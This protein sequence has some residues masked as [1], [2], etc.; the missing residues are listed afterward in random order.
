VSFQ[1]QGLSYKEVLLEELATCRL[2]I[3]ILTPDDQ[4]KQPRRTGGTGLLGRD[5]VVF[6]AGLAA[7]RYGFERTM[8]LAETSVDLPT[9]WSGLIHIPF[10]IAEVK[11]L[12][13]ALEQPLAQ[14]RTAIRGQS[15]VI[16]EQ[17]RLLDRQR[18]DGRYWYLS[19]V[20]VGPGYQGVVQD[21]LDREADHFKQKHGVFCE[22]AGVLFGE[23]DDF[24]IF[25]APS[26][27]AATKFVT[28]LR[29]H[30]PNIVQVDTRQIFPGFYWNEPHDDLPRPRVEHLILINC[31]PHTVE[32]VY[33]KLKDL[34]AEA[35]P[36]DVAVL[37]IG[38]I[39]G[40]HDIFL[41]ASAPNI[42]SFDRFIT[43]TLRTSGILGHLTDNTTSLRIGR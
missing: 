40:R 16:D 18:A 36:H 11:D 12:R 30:V 9:D 1:A 7:G 27:E 25:S 26:I 33:N 23:Y 6:E 2:A 8:I 22:K 31:V 28:E 41:I 39:F 3:F 34:T 15:A 38:I 14:L 5:H 19:M 35:S 37:R 4:L 43:D 17:E 20:R 21:Q 29:W 10:S 32:R 24:L 13:A 42:E